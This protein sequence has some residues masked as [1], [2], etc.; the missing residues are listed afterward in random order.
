MQI[1]ISN[2]GVLGTP[3][4]A[5][6]THGEEVLTFNVALFDKMGYGDERYDIFEHINAYW[7]YLPP[8]KQDAIFDVYRRIR[9]TFFTV[10]DQHELTAGLYQLV[11]E[12][13]TYHELSDV[14][15][16][17]D[18]HS[19]III[20]SVFKDVYVESRDT[21]GTRERTYLKEDYRWL[22]TLSV[23]LRAMVPVW[24]EFI[25]LTKDST[26]TV[27][28]EF[29]AHKLMAYSSIAKSEP[30][31]RLRV[32]VEH[33][34]PA[35]KSKAAAILGGISTEDFPDWILG[36][37]LVRKLS[38]GDV[39]GIDQDSHL[40]TFIYK[41]IANKVK[42]HD[43][44]FV[45][46]VKDK[47]FDGNGQDVEHNLSKL[48]GYK[49]K[50]GIPA[51]DPAIISHYIDDPIRLAKTI[52]PD[53]ETKLV[54]DSLKSIQALML[55]QI[56][57]PQIVLTQWVLKKA[58]NPRGLLHVPKSTVLKAMAV[59]Q[60]LLWHREHFALAALLS[61]AEQTNQADLQLGGTE[62]RARIPKDMIDK[63]TELYPY[64]RMP[65]GK[66]KVIRRINPAEESINS[67]AV[68][69]SQRDWRLTLPTPWVAK[70][71]GNQL[72]RNYSVPHNVKVLLAELTIQLA[73][74]TF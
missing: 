59:A 11:K 46:L 74:R 69:F 24:G 10:Y 2:A 55:V 67:V 64:P 60:A 19:N 44:N 23:A 15:H 52:C 18:F 25:K 63:L 70:I 65:S 14:R 20:P 4:E 22:V 9:E 47:I 39:R 57:P 42:G 68:A 7:N 48:E 73:T 49:I 33:S 21:P 30:M 62:S 29:Y 34:L 31:A 56:W 72:N 54:E 17:I 36:L 61:S 13:F 12:L 16:W 27:F 58:V 50:E 32:Y 28:K 8:Q 38:I 6:M 45:G 71:T 51:G 43:N 41:Y 26:G 35:D 5:Q 3:T 66:Q 53:I 37:V 40:I 1:S